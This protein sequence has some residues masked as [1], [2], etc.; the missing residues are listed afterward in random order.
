MNKR[1]KKVFIK[2]ASVVLMFIFFTCI[3]SFNI[4]KASETKVNID[5]ISMN[6]FHGALEEVPIKD[7]NGNIIAM[8]GATLMVG[9]YNAIK[10]KNPNGT[11]LVSAGDMFQGTPISNV[12]LGKPVVQ[13]MNEMGTQ[14]MTL[15]NHEFDW[16]LEKINLIKSEADFP[17][18]SCNIYDKTTGRRVTF[19]QPYKIIKNQGVNIGFIGVTTPETKITTIPEAVSNLEFRDPAAEVK[20]L[21]TEIKSKGVDIII[22]VGHIGATEYKDGTIKGEAADLAKSLN[23][24]EV[25]AIIS[26]HTHTQVAGK[27]NNISIV[28]GWKNGRNLGHITIVYNTATKKVEASTETFEDC[29]N[30]YASITRDEDVRLIVN[31]A[32]KEIGPKFD[33]ILGSASANIIHSKDSES[34]VGNWVTDTMTKAVAADFGFESSGSLRCNIQKGNITLREIYTLMPWDNHVYT[35]KLTGTQI[36]N[37]LEHGATLK[38]GMVQVSGLKFKYYKDN[39]E[40]SKVFDIKDSKEKEICMNKLYTVAV[41]EFLATG[42]DNYIEFTKGIDVHDT[43]YL[44]R[45]LV[46]KDLQDLTAKGKQLSAVIDKRI[47]EVKKSSKKITYLQSVSYFFYLNVDHI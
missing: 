16:G 40:G 27:V 26:G 12:L 6:D 32:K 46:I 24:N 39:A 7:N 37:I 11:I 33:A 44:E 15:G 38:Y 20:S 1:N 47:V 4:A 5:I 25:S 9:K 41:N 21:I 18:L 23:S 43:G 42:G 30:S 31:A 45:D 22:V 34:A 10:A 28:Q 14:L 13:I 19:A 36:K 29:Y 17:M 2:T 3:F 35:M 8:Q